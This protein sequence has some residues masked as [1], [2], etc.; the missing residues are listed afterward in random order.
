MQDIPHI[1]IVDDEII[2]RNILAKMLHGLGFVAMQAGNSTE[3]QHALRQHKPDIILLDMMMPGVNSMEVLKS[4]RADQN[5]DHTAIILISGSND[6]NAISTYIE[7]GINDFLPKPFNKALL[8]LKI[9]TCLNHIHR[10]HAGQDVSL[11]ME[12]F[13]R[14]LSHDL[15]NALTGIMMTAEL[16]LMS[17][18]STQNKQHI[19]EIIESTEEVSKLIKRRR[20]SLH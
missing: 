16:L 10:Q 7:A 14:D 1:L 5:L 12:T 17:E 4:V 9:N 18:T 11:N 2:V 13:C 15:N 20:E 6:L 3:A 8:S 19:T